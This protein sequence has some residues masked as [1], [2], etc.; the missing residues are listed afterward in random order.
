MH[1]TSKRKEQVAAKFA[2]SIG[3]NIREGKEISE[4]SFDQAEKKIE[5]YAA[6]K[7]NFLLEIKK[8]SL[9]DAISYLWEEKSFKEIATK[10]LP[11]EYGQK[12]LH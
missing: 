2:N 4:L 10:I 8:L 1:L 3:R 11:R 5:D 12:L 7:I 9:E 6:S